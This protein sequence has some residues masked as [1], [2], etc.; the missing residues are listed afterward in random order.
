[1]C[2]DA[3]FRLP[4]PA[5]P[6]HQGCAYSIPTARACTRNDGRLVSNSIVSALLGRDI[7]IYGDGTHTR[8]FCY[9]DDLIDGLMRFMDTASGVTGPINLGNPEEISVAELAKLILDLTGSRAR[10]VH[11]K[12]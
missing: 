6:R 5:P 2:R 9:V 8:S 11:R 7:T 3:I 12:R 1:M 10:L 4:A